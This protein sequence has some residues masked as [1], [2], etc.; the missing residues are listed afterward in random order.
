VYSRYPSIHGDLI[1]DFSIKR[2]KK[3]LN[4]LNKQIKKTEK[5]VAKKSSSKKNKVCQKVI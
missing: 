4:D 3:Q 2:Y 1:C 5:F